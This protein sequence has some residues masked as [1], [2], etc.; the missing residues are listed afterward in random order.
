[1][2]T[3]SYIQTAVLP[4]VTTIFFFC[5]KCSGNEQFSLAHAKAVARATRAREPVGYEGQLY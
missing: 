1:M 4:N 5:S 2:Y 3:P